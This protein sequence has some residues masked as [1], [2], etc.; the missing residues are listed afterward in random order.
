MNKTRIILSVTG[1]VIALVVLVMAYLVWD[2]FSAKTA[3]LEGDD[4]TEG[5]ATVV[6]KVKSL[7][8]KNPF[9]CVK[10]EKMLV[11]NRQALEAWRESARKLASRGDWC[12]DAGC[13][14]AQF[15]ERIAR[16]A[17]SLAALQGPAG[18]PIVGAD[19]AF[20]PFKD[21]L[22]DKMPT[23][24]Q[25]GKLQ[26]QWFDV[27]ALL[28]LLST[29]GVA[30]VTDLQAVEK[31]AVEL[32]AVQKGAKNKKA[33]KAKKAE[34]PVFQPSVETYALTFQASPAALAEVI[35]ALSFQER[36]TVVE[37]FSFSR[38]RDAIATALGGNEKGEAQQAQQSG[39][40]R[41]R[42]GAA[43]TVGEEASVEAP[44]QNANVFD[45]KKD[46]ALRV[47]LKVSVYDFRTLE[48]EKEESK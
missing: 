37:G 33:K 32:P 43:A 28:E 20:G 14:P 47:E 35:R 40:R 24:E 5:L 29:N 23:K 41:R 2:A 27:T 12:A 1:G 25:L 45:P 31:P 30:Q 15:K 13:T 6:R 4:E 8:G 48:E 3:A 39:R 17:K 46:A 11:Q 21:Y 10:N 16:D 19:F 22:A 34:K 18:T 44:A 42:G 26:R 36:F 38:E 9:P 7:Q